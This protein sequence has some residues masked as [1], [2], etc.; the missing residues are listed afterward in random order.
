[1]HR[2]ADRYKPIDLTW[3]LCPGGEAAGGRGRSPSFP[4]QKGRP[5]GP[6]SS[7]ATTVYS[8]TLPFKSHVSGT[9]CC[10]AKKTIIRNSIINLFYIAQ[11]YICKYPKSSICELQY[12]ITLLVLHIIFNFKKWFP[13][14]VKTYLRL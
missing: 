4:S 3:K 10:H 2:S 12:S 11:K 1:M 9:Q 7:I 5:I 13:L 8:T 14:A 6:R